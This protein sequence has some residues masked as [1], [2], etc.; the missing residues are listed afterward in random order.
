[1]HSPNAQGFTLHDGVIRFNGRIWVGNNSAVQTKIISALHSSAVGGHSG[2]LA[3]YHRINKLFWWKGLKKDVENFVKQCQ[4]CQQ[5]KH[6]LTSP[7]GLLQPLPIPAGAWQ[8]ISLD[9][10]EGL[11]KS[12]GYTVILVVVDRFTK[13][14][15]FIPLKHPYTAL[16]VAR[17]LFDTVVKLHGLPKS[18]VSDRDKIF[19]S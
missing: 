9:F 10:V 3:T 2:Q 19:T 6:L 17:V 12:D 11:P 8:N 15:H 13:Y 16:T 5:A 18:M 4:V 1:M 7:P 14:A